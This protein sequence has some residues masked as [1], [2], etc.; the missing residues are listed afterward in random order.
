MNLSVASLT[1]KGDPAAKAWI[2][3]GG[4]RS[5]WH[6]DKFKKEF[7]NEPVYRRTLKEESDCLGLMISVLK[8][9]K[10]YKKTLQDLDPSLQALIQ[11]QEAGLLEPYV[12]F[13]RLDADIAKDYVPYRDAH[14]ENVLRYLDEF[15][16]PKTPQGAAQ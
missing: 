2:V 11:I 13:G 9:Q 1:G 7:P 3:Y 4:N 8:E 6:G 14:R 16:V 15:L 10:D 5:L 12:L